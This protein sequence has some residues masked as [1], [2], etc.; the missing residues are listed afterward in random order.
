[1]AATDA[2]VEMLK[3]ATDTNGLIANPAAARATVLARLAAEFPKHA[4]LPQG[5]AR[6]NLR[7]PSEN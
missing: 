3:K 1:M 6:F 7:G 4:R 5:G 2:A